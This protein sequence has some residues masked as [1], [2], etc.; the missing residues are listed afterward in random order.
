MNNDLLEG[1]LFMLTEKSKILDELDIKNENQWQIDGSNYYQLRPADNLI[2]LDLIPMLIKLHD[3]TLKNTQYQR[4]RAIIHYLA[5]TVCWQFNVQY[6]E[7]IA[8]DGIRI[9]ELID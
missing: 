8:N 7:S 1:T 9:C 5:Q 6:D 2:S 4:R 3:F